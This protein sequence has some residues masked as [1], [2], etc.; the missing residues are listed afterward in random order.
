[1]LSNAGF[2]GVIYSNAGSSDAG[3]LVAGRLNVAFIFA[4]DSG[5]LSCEAFCCAGGATRAT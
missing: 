4:L 2:N 5:L 3:L 1:M